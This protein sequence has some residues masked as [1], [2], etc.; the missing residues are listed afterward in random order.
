MMQVAV[1]FK[2]LPNLDRVLDEDWESFSQSPSLGYAGLDFNC[3]DRSA[4]EIGLKIKEQAAVRETEVSCTALTVCESV[5]E[6]LLSGLYAVGFDRVICLSQE[7]REFKP[8]ETAALLART[9]RELGADLVI[10]GAAASMAET[11][12]VPYFL[13]RELDLPILT[14]VEEAAWQE[15]GLW[16][17][18]RMPEGL[19]EKKAA[20]PV[21]CAI[22]NSPEVLRCATLRAQM[23]CRGKKPELLACP[24]EGERPAPGLERP[25]TGRTCTMLDPKDGDVVDK[26][27]SALRSAAREDGGSQEGEQNNAP[28]LGLLEKSALVVRP[29]GQNGEGYEKLAEAYRKDAPALVL[30]PEDQGGKILAARLAEDLHL[31]CFFGGELL[32]LTEDAVT[33]R[34]RACAANLLWTET[35]ALPAVITQPATVLD[36]WN[37]GKALHLPDGERPGWLLEETL[38][39]PTRPGA[40]RTADLV[41]ACG[42]GMGSKEACDRARALADKLGAG[43]GL[44][45]PSALDLWGA[46]TEIIGLSGSLIAPRCCLVLGAAGA[47]AFAVGIEKAEQIIAVNTDPDALIFKNAD[48]GLLMD[49]RLLV[50]KL[51]ENLKTEGENT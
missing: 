24:E 18:C 10:T 8:R 21:L 46:P 32:G 36:K 15:D 44:T 33:L 3:F 48:L 47:G 5:P 14:E 28:W 20:L 17:K 43:F 37:S 12:M 27:L 7:Q 11:G 25:K 6:T 49:A 23:K 4:L 40:L 35:L 22:G 39:E 1:C 16:T 30:L 2:I 29:G 51:M 41:I 13:A 50:E 26:L 42:S 34:K 19:V 38:V 9:I 31:N 45:R